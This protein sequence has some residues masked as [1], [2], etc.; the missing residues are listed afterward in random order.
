MTSFKQ[1]LIMPIELFHVINNAAINLRPANLVYS[2]LQSG[3]AIIQDR[4]AAYPN[5]II[6]AQ[7]LML[8]TDLV[9]LGVDYHELHDSMSD[10]RKKYFPIAAVAS[11]IFAAAGVFYL[12]RYAP[13]AADLKKV[14]QGL[15]SQELATTVVK[16]SNPMAH[17]ISAFLH[18][19]RIS[20]NV[21]TAASLANRHSFIH[22]A[23]AS[24]NALTLHKISKLPWVLFHKT[25]TATN[26]APWPSD[27]FHNNISQVTIQ[28]HFLIRDDLPAT[29]KAVNEYFTNFFNHCS[30][31]KYWK[32]VLKPLTTGDKNNRRTI[33]YQTREFKY[34]VTA[35]PI[36]PQFT[37]TPYINGI[38]AWVIDNTMGRFKVDLFI[39]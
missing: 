35:Q 25:L 36:K 22:L 14:L 2:A 8:I 23:N 9:A 17:N 18:L 24:L 38:E 5:L 1:R 11:V 6:N 27:E 21:M 16:W 19:M 4:S 32:T 34:K 33:Y 26:G 31:K 28:S 15:S 39:K 37:I 12:N 13:P 29:L 20:V 3:L 7:R 10:Q 30:V